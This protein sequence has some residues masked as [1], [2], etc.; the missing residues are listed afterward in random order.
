VSKKEILQSYQKLHPQLESIQRTIESQ[1]RETLNKAGIKFHSLSGRVKTEKS[2]A[3]KLSR[4]DRNYLHLLDITDL[5]AFRVIVYSEDIIQSVAE[6]IEDLFAID[7]AN[8]A[9]KLVS[10]DNQKFGYRSLHY[11]CALPKLSESA[12]HPD[13]KDLHFE[14]QIRTI[15]QHAWAEVEHELGYKAGPEF[16]G[17]FRRRFSQL[18]SLLEIADREFASLRSDILTYQSKLKSKMAQ[19]NG[20]ASEPMS[21]DQFSIHQITSLPEVNHLDQVL[22]Q[23]LGKPQSAIEFFPEYLLLALKT[24]GIEDRHHL[25]EHMNFDEED[26]RNFIRLYFDFAQKKWNF[27]RTSIENVQ[28][29]Y[30]LLFISHLAILN[31]E[32]LLI[33]CVNR[34]TY[35]Y[36]KLDH[37]DQPHLA[38]QTAEELVN[39]LAAHQWFRRMKS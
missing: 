21:I 9:N 7:F 25:K 37:P 38:K 31:S 35:F 17:Q 26:F 29:G 13:L 36:Q 27:G 19:P 6:S 8:S 34:L 4:P 32:T 10:T 30:S 2:L 11:V 15:L 20:D 1:L 39:H 22:C 3:F 16:S 23:E 24:V 12:P 5:L 28:R 18:A 14:I 33:D